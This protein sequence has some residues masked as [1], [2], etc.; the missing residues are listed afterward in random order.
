MHRRAD[1]VTG[2]GSALRGCKPAETAPHL[3]AFRLGFNVG[4]V[5][6]GD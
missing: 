4:C 1:A 3:Y 5:Q 2:P 6:F